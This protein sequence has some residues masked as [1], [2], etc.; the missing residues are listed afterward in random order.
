MCVRPG[1]AKNS[2]LKS[3]LRNV[4]IGIVGLV[5]PTFGQGINTP[6]RVIYVSVAP[7]VGAACQN[8]QA[9]QR[10]LQAGATN[11]HLYSCQ[12]SLWVDISG[13]GGGA[14]TG[15]AGGVLS[16]T[17]PDPGLATSV[18]LP[19]NPTTTTQS[20]GNNS[21]RV[22]TT[23]Y[24][25]TGLATKGSGTVTS[26][27]FTGGLISIANPTTTPAFTVAGTSGGIICFTSTSAWASSAL[28]A[29][30][31]LVIGGG[32]GACPSSSGISFVGSILTLPGSLTITGAS[33]SISMPM[34]AGDTTDVKFSSSTTNGNSFFSI[35]PNGSGNR[36]EYLSYNSSSQGNQ[37]AAFGYGSGGASVISGSFANSGNPADYLVALGSTTYLSLPQSIA[38]MIGIGGKT[39]SFPGL[40]P[41]SGRLAIKLAD[42]SAFTEVRATRYLSSGTAPSINSGFGTSPSITGGDGSFR[43]TIG[44]GGTANVGVVKFAIAT[45]NPATCFANDETTRSVAVQVVPTTVTSGNDGITL[46]AT[47]MST[48]LVTPFG[49]G[50]TIAVLCGGF[51]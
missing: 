31:E 28:L 3:F 48:G 36:S 18:A 47:L 16:G 51:L 15:P 30:S 34:S 39:S 23:A 17:Y 44:T 20:Q 5:L 40:L 14:P 49:A 7:T 11:G 22:A 32:A 12:S 19:G 21:T 9:M 43:V 46:N 42:S 6:A 24:V 41:I 37:Y 4:L 13:S 38:N 50:D 1:R 29:S 33:R 45:T 35:A 2:M 8:T 26:V 10:S 25:D 27:G